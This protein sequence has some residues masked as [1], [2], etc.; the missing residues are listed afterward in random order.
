MN[1]DK[2]I[3]LKNKIDEIEAIDIFK[4]KKKKF[5]IKNVQKIKDTTICF[6]PY[7]YIFIIA[8]VEYLLKKDK[9][10]KFEMLV[11]GIEG[12]I[13]FIHSLLDNYREK[14]INDINRD[15]E[16]NFLP[17]NICKEK[18]IEKARRTISDIF[19][20]KS[21]LVKNIKHDFKWIKKVYYPYW[22]IFVEDK[23]GCSRLFSVNA[24][25]SEIDL[26]IAHFYTDHLKKR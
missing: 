20:K 11:E 3:F 22:I 19:I 2:I 21:L 23:K 10:I 5:F 26:R 14:T 17:E 18:A 1:D 15:Q 6:S 4:K 12:D 16:L 8:E 24:L 25:N 7:W 13:L 9:K